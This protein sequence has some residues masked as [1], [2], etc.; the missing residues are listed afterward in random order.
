MAFCGYREGFLKKTKQKRI[1]R[2]IEEQEQSKHRT[3]REERQ[4]GRR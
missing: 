4:K 2:G 3:G 1:W